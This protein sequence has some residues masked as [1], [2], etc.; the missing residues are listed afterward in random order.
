[1]SNQLD[2]FNTPPHVHQATSYRAAL[3]IKQH[4]PKLR[5]LVLG[6]IDSRGEI[7]ATCD[8]AEQKLNLSHQCC[9]ARIRELYQD[10]L[11]ED[12]GERRK[13]RSGR[14]AIVWKIQGK[15]G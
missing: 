6:F 9:S 12:S 14:K 13:T 3:E 5:N 2:I 15:A 8:E 11:I 4:A 10:G 7:G 1:M